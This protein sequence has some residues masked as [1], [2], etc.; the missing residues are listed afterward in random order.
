MAA[1]K[2][3]RPG[4]SRKAQFSIFATYVLAISGAIVGG[5]LLLIS[6]LDPK[7][8]SALRI[9][10]AEA[11]A[12]V[13]RFFNSVRR[14]IS[15]GSENMSF[16]WDAAAKNK[17]M[18]KRIE[19]L[20]KENL[21]LKLIKLEN[22][23]L[24][25]LINSIEND[26][27]E[28]ITTGRLIS[29]SASS[30]RR[31]AVISVESTRD[32]TAGQPVVSPDGLI[33]RITEKGLST[34]RILLVTD[35]DN[36]VPVIRLSDGLAA[37]ATGRADGSLLIKPLNLGENPFEKGD[38]LVTS[39]NGGLYPPNIPVA[40]IIAKSDD[41]GVA[42]PLADPATTDYSSILEIYDPIANQEIETIREEADLQDSDA[43]IP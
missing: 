5:L 26:Q 34:A 4:F 11:T 16:Y 42:K 43:V 41:S 7:G 3:R 19:E 13:G 27:L 37:F 12:P 38:I 30:G 20:E 6:I 28:I 32:M 39:G 33:G 8:F 14:T 18:D 22:E 25:P 9:V 21:A 10:G 15:D 17:A 31:L 29:T 24:R 40:T 23:K 36:V 35:T 2:N 1:P